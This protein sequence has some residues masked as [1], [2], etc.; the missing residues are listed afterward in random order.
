MFWFRCAGADEETAVI[1]SSS[2]E[3]N[4]F[5][6][7][8]LAFRYFGESNAVVIVC[9]VLICKNEPIWKLTE[10]CKRCGQTA[11]KRKRRKADDDDDDEDEDV[12]EKTTVSSK[13][14]FII[15]KQEQ[16]RNLLFLF[17][18]T[19]CTTFSVFPKVFLIKKINKETSIQNSSAK[20]KI[21]NLIIITTYHR[22]CRTLYPLENLAKSL[23]K[24]TRIPKT[25]I[26]HLENHCN[27]GPSPPEFLSC[28]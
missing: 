15:K 21:L 17:C 9:E 26:P 28:E 20:A 4:Y 19:F 24:V 8:L 16:P 27:F 1:T 6:W 10:E 12:I 7:E 5:S 18:A 13:P 14:F 11:N 25:F 2:N 22:Y 3:L 23:S